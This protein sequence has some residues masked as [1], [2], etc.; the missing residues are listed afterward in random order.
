MASETGIIDAGYNDAH[1]LKQSPLHVAVVAGIGDP[2]HLEFPKTYCND[3]V[4]R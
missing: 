4:T 3:N 2:G 1:R